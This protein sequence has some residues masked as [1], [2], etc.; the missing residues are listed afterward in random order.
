MLD[1]LKISDIRTRYKDQ[2]VVVEVTKVDKHNNPL[3]GCVLFHGLDEREVYSQGPQ[4]RQTHPQADLFYFY[5]GNL[6]PE[7]IGVMLVEI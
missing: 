4:Y 5:A 1:D 7:G 3:R 6:I 2:W